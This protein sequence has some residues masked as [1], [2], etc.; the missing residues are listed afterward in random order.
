MQH[1][2]SIVAAFLA[3]AAAALPACSSS[4]KPFAPTGAGSYML[5]VRDAATD[6]PVEGVTVRAT[7]AGTQ[8]RGTKPADAV[9]DEDGV[10]VLRFGDWGAIDLR[11]EQ[12]EV[13]ERWMVTQGRVAVNGGKAA[14]TPLR[15]MVGSRSN[16]GASAYELSITRIERGGKVDN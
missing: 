15:L 16:G 3:L 8:Q 10:A 11:I 4:P 5:T 12:G 7:G 9:T 14:R 2:R 6:R 1:A 13:T